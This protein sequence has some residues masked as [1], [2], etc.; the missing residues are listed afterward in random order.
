MNDRNIT[1]PR[2]IYWPVFK[3]KFSKFFKQLSKKKKKKKKKKEEQFVNKI[4]YTK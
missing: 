2:A 3:R 4:H 1:Q